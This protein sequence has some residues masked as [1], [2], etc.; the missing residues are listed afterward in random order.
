MGGSSRLSRCGNLPI[1]IAVVWLTLPNAMQ[2]RSKTLQFYP[3]NIVWLATNL[4]PLRWH[5]P[6]AKYIGPFMAF[7]PVSNKIELPHH[8]CLSFSFHKFQFKAVTPDPLDSE[9]SLDIYPPNHSRS[10]DGL[11]T[12]TCQVHHSISQA[13]RKLE[14]LVDWEGPD[15]DKFITEVYMLLWSW[16]WQC[17]LLKTP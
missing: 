16:F 14:H 7:N 13:K 8:C 3:G 12:S 11:L 5:K 6:L 2:I 17:K 1:S 9:T 15:P 4:R 10:M